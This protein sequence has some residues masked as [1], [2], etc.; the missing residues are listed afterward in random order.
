MPVIR[1]I[2]IDLF[3]IKLLNYYSFSLLIKKVKV[4]II[5]IIALVQIQIELFQQI[6]LAKV[7]DSRFVWIK[8]YFKLKLKN[9][10]N[11]GIWMLKR[12]QQLF[13][14][15]NHE[16]KVANDHINKIQLQLGSNIS[17][18][19]SPND[20]LSRYSQIIEISQFHK[21]QKSLDL[22]KL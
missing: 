15:F 18:L 17:I 14:D 4:P 13:L 22:R 19:M 5:T 21:Q 8:S 20:H 16:N 11:K 12:Q 7:R 1:I 3:I 10:Q 6:I 2:K 9:V